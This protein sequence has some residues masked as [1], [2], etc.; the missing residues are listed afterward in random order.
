MVGGAQII[1]MPNNEA[2][3]TAENKLEGYKA[4]QISRATE[5]MVYGVMCNAPQ[6]SDDMQRSNASHGNSMIVGKHTRNPPVQ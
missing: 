6:D 1:F 2:G 3:L 5:N 4:M